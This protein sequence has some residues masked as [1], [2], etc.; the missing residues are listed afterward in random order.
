MDNE[1]P[2]SFDRPFNVRNMEELEAN[3]VGNREDLIKKL[4]S[5][6]IKE[7]KVGP[8]HIDVN[9]DMDF[10]TGQVESVLRH[11]IDPRLSLD[12]ADAEDDADAIHHLEALK[13]QGRIIKKKPTAKKGC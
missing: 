13:K 7:S 2:S 1:K 5:T 4:K 12:M 11:T 10:G 3:A 9:K 8:I 6:Q